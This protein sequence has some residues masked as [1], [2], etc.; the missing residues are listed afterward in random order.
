MIFGLEKGNPLMTDLRPY[1]LVLHHPVFYHLRRIDCNQCWEN[2]VS[3]NV[4][5]MTATNNTPPCDKTTSRLRVST[6]RVEKGR[7]LFCEAIS[8]HFNWKNAI[9]YYLTRVIWT[10]GVKKACHMRVFYTHDSLRYTAQP[11]YKLLSDWS[12]HGIL[13]QTVWAHFT[14]QIMKKRTSW[15]PNCHKFDRTVGTVGKGSV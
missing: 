14:W 15:T 6:K 8:R 2:A 1:R 9:V 4:M 7:V 13:I 3:W 12:Q 10:A 11:E 5:D